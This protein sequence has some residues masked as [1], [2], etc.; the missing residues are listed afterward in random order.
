MCK[1]WF[2]SLGRYQHPV[3]PR[4]VGTEDTLSALGCGTDGVV[5]RAANSSEWRARHALT[6]KTRSVIPAEKSSCSKAV[7]FTSINMCS[8]S[9]DMLYILKPL[10]E[11]HVLVTP[12][13]YALWMYMDPSA[14][15]PMYLRETTHQSHQ[16]RS[17]CTLQ[18]PPTRF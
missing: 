11:S 5:F 16:S 15:Y 9:M 1:A 6:K 17:S 10:P 8:S 12:S 13:R 3:P 7:P 18:P 4:P 2:R 14:M